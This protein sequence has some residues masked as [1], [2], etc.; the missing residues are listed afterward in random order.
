MNKFATDES[1]MVDRRTAQSV[2]QLDRWAF[3]CATLT[4]STEGVISL[5]Y[6]VRC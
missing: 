5:G 6:L 2:K 4:S 3:S 1:A